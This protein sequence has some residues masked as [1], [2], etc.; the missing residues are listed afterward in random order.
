[1]IYQV[2]KG[3]WELQAGDHKQNKIKVI[4]KNRRNC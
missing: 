3:Y 2:P 4:K 1:M